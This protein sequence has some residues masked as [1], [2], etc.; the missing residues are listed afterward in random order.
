MFSWRL[1]KSFPFFFNCLGDNT[2]VIYICRDNIIIF[3]YNHRMM[4]AGLISSFSQFLGPRL[5]INFLKYSVTFDPQK[6]SDEWLS[7][8]ATQGPPGRSVFQSG[9]WYHSGLILSCVFPL[10]V[11]YNEKRENEWRGRKNIAVHTYH[12]DV[13]RSVE[14]QWQIFL[15]VCV[16]EYL[17][18]GLVCSLEWK[19]FRRPQTPAP[20]PR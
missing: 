18:W 13:F 8:S 10:S 12:P 7:S 20:R 16:S 5:T 6:K 14:I 17:T 4:T 2:H 11:K 9:I 1:V 3:I 19:W 15:S